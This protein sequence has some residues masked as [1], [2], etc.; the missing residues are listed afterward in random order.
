MNKSALLAILLFILGYY[1]GK[2]SA[3]DN[4]QMTINECDTHEGFLVCKLEEGEEDE[5]NRKD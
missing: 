3:Q 5:H 2:D 4:Q 1:L